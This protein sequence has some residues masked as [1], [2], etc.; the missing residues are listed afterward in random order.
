MGTATSQSR[1]VPILW[2]GLVQLHCYPDTIK[3]RSKWYAFHSYHD[4]FESPCPFSCDECRFWDSWINPSS[5]AFII[6]SVVDCQD[7]VKCLVIAKYFWLLY[8][9]HENVSV[10]LP[11]FLTVRF[12]IIGFLIFRTL[13][14]SLE[15]WTH[16]YIS[17]LSILW[18]NFWHRVVISNLPLHYISWQLLG[19]GQALSNH[20]K[21]IAIAIRL[22]CVR[23]ARVDMV[24]MTSATKSL[25]SIT[26]QSPSNYEGFTLRPSLPQ[27]KSRMQSNKSIH[28]VLF[29]CELS[30]MRH[31]GGRW[32]KRHI[33]ALPWPLPWTEGT[34]VATYSEAEQPLC[35]IT[36]N[37][38]SS[39]IMLK[40]KFW[41][42]MHSG[43]SASPYVATPVAYL[44]L[45]Y[46]SLNTGSHNTTLRM[47]L[48]S[49]STPQLC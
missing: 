32:E 31:C 39:V 17:W 41:N 4:R 8:T 30:V 22:S 27:S 29:L 26:Y 16:W 21:S 23:L 13:L 1:V 25:W 5:H 44:L 20:T 35:T 3:Y 14:S 43:R 9:S 12:R 19:L 34:G 49:S 36:P 28:D 37:F 15:V 24:V 46:W 45:T 11:K 40:W 6:Y 33:L 7:R 38:H 47:C 42:M 48:S 18:F 2:R 10:M